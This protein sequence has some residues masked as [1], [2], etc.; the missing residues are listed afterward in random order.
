MFHNLLS[1]RQDS[2]E[3]TLASDGDTQMTHGNNGGTTHNDGAD[4]APGMVAQVPHGSD[5][6][7]THGTDAQVIRG[8]YGQKAHG[9]DR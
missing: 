7:V 5:I 3:V 2:N 9:G 4:V 8:S 6:W 1:N